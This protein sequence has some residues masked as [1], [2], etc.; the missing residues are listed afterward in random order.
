MANKKYDYVK[1]KGLVEVTNTARKELEKPIVSDAC[2]FIQQQFNDFETDRVKN[3]FTGIEFVRDKDVPQF[4][5]VKCSSRK[6]FARYMKHRGMHDKNSR[7]G[8]AA[9]IT[10]KELD[11]AMRLIREK[12]PVKE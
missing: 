12:Y 4:Y 5:Q 2:G 6:E 1:G 3:G 10:Q 11:D 8:S 7:N 9:G